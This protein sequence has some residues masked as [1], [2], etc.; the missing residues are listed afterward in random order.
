MPP[1]VGSR[2]INLC[3]Y[4]NR[5]TRR[6]WLAAKRSHRPQQDCRNKKQAIQKNKGAGALGF[7]ELLS[8]C[9][10]TGDKIQGGV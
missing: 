4:T 5:N 2:I 1:A 10:N 9:Q 7:S 3:V 6:Q 8:T